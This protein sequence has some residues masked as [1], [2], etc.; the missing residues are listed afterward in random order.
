[1]PPASH[2]GEGRFRCRTQAA[3]TRGSSAQQQ[4]R[5]Q[6]CLAAAT[7]LHEEWCAREVVCTAL[8]QAP[9]SL[10][11]HV[12]TRVHISICPWRDWGRE[13]GA[14][15]FFIICALCMSY[16]RP[17]GLACATHQPQSCMHACGGCW[18]GGSV[19]HC[20]AACVSMDAP[21]AL[22][23]FSSL[24]AMPSARALRALYCSTAR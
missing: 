12:G 6:T 20:D 8:W 11:C 23:P 1:M 17:C 10:P 9:G 18:V 14:F 15:R 16:G 2:P 13:G 21:A 22:T 3:P 7:P 4:G 24:G 19:I 5:E